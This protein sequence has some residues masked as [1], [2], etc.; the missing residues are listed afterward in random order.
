MDQELISNWDSTLH[1]EAQYTGGYVWF[2]KDY[3]QNLYII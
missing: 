2:S 3:I 1:T